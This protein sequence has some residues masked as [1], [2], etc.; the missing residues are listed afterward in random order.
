L[1]NSFLPHSFLEE[2]P[3]WLRS[4]GLSSVCTGILFFSFPFISRAQSNSA[5]E[6]GSENVRTIEAEMPDFSLASSISGFHEQIHD[7]F[8]PLLLPDNSAT[9]PEQDGDEGLDVIGPQPQGVNEAHI[10]L[11]PLLAKWHEELRQRGGKQPTDLETGKIV[12]GYNWKGLLWESFGFF[13]VQNSWRLATDPF[14]RKLTADYPYWHDYIASLK[15]WNIRRWSDGDDFLVAWVGHPMQGAVTSYIE[16]QNDPHARYLEISATSAYWKSRFWGMMWANLYSIDQKVGPLGEAALG[17][18]GGYTYIIGCP[19]PCKSYN[20]AVNKVTNNTGWVKFVSTP[21]GGTVWVIGEDFLDRYVSERF[22][23][24]HPD[25]LFPKILR[26]SLNPT[27]TAANLLRGKNPWYRDYEHPAD[28]DLI[29]SGSVHFERSDEDVI[30]HLPRYEF[31]PHFNAISLPV[32]TQSCSHCRQM[33]IG[34]GAGFSWRFSRWWDFD[35]DV[36][37]QPNASPLPSDRAGGDVVMGTFGLRSGLQTPNYSLKASVRPGFVSYNRAYM[38]SPSATNPAPGIGRIT[39]FAT[40]LAISGDY[41]LTRH[42]AIRGSFGNTAVRYREPY[43]Q[44]PGV[45]HYPYLNW[46]SKQNFLTNENW[47]YQVGPVLRF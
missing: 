11:L 39:H 34:T 16:I 9:K 33:T 31:F 47:T 22:R 44:A 45:G 1:L 32:N 25:R 42:L 37:Y 6:P 14:F 36:D 20:P 15:Q 19:F 27:R 21:V 5:M 3:L 46:L 4:V 2:V 40:V 35:S 41:G 26:G 23:E 17:S 29:G 12:Q 13:G 8:P 7:G 28:A 24:A 30:R 10:D 38:T 18:E 43:L